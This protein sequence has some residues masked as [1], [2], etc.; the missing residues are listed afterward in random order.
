MQKECV[1]LVAVLISATTVGESIGSLDAFSSSIK[2]FVCLCSWV[3][4]ELMQYH[5]VC[6]RPIEVAARHTMRCE[7]TTVLQ[8]A[9]EY[10][11]GLLGR[12]LEKSINS[13]P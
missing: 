8:L 6:E 7:I 9:A 13:C 5:A 11:R 3:A 10:R 2:I 1:R 4:L 12:F